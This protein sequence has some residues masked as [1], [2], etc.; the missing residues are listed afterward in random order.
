VDT[1]AFGEETFEPIEEGASLQSEILE[2]ARAGDDD[3]S[4]YGQAEMLDWSS[5]ALG[6]LFGSVAS[7][8]RVYMIHWGEGSG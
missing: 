7:S 6:A 4:F 1:P 2:W 8:F 3:A 5:E